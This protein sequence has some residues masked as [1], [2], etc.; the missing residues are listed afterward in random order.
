MG[1]IK[2]NCDDQALDSYAF[3]YASM[4]MHIIDYLYINAYKCTI[5]GLNLHKKYLRATPK[6]F[7]FYQTAVNY[8]ETMTERVYAREIPNIIANTLTERRNVMLTFVR[9]NKY[10]VGLNLL[11]NRLRAIINIIP[12]I[13]LSHSKDQFKTFCKV[14]LIQKGLLSQ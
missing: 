4:Q 14:N 3:A 11:S 8:Y 5:Y 7:S 13:C 6:L 2:I 10:K 1:K 9:S 12:K